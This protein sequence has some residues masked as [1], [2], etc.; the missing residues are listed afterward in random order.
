[1]NSWKLLTTAVAA[2][3]AAAPQQPQDTPIIRMNVELV[4]VDAVV[5]DGKGRH[6]SDLKPEDFEVRQDGKVVKITNFSYVKDTAPP[7]VPPARRV[8]GEVAAPP[9]KSDG[10]KPG[11]VRRTMA[12]VVDDLAL[13]FDGVSYVKDALL[14]FVD[15]QMEPG[16][17]VAVMRTSKGAGSLQ[18]F[19]SDKRLLRAAVEQVKF[20]FRNRV[21]QDSLPRIFDERTA[22]DAAQGG[23]TGNQGSTPVGGAQQ[24]LMQDLEK[25]QEARAKQQRE[26]FERDF[27]AVG[28]LGTLHYLMAGM[29]PLPGRKSVV[30]FSENLTVP[31]WDSTGIPIL[32]QLRRVTDEANRA[33]VVF[34]SVDPRG[35]PVLGF[36]AHDQVYDD[37]KNTSSDVL[38]QMRDNRRELYFNSRVG[39]GFLAEQT[40]GIYLGGVNDIPGLLGKAVADQSGYYLIGYRP[41]EG[42]FDDSGKKR[43]YHEIKV[44]VLPAGLH[45]RSRNGFYN[46]SESEAAAE[47][48]TPAQR[49]A[50]ALVSPFAAGEIGLQLTPVF[51]VDG[52]TGPTVL[53]MMH[54]DAKNLTFVDDGDGWRRAALNVLTTTFGEDG[55][56]ADSHQ[57][58]FKMRMNEARYRQIV[59]D[60]LIYTMTQ[61]VK[62]SGAFQ[63]RAVVGDINGS[64]LGS[65]SEFIEVPNLKK[66]KLALSG[67]LLMGAGGA[68]S[69]EEGVAAYTAG[70]PAIRHFRRGQKISYG[71]KVLNATVKGKDG[72][73]DV[74]TQVRLFRGDKE[75]FR[76]EPR[77]LQ[78][79]GVKEKSRLLVGG[80]LQLVPQFEPGDYALQLVVW[81]KL[82]KGGEAVAAQAIDFELD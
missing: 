38:L 19:T 16:D 60:G 34:Y 54:I 52:K 17:L 68:Q 81:D 59:K 4:Q 72:D 50:Q 53:T 58:L 45:S 48:M 70:H 28:T 69:D 5:T 12:L 49:L 74:W 64:K 73:P 2:L 78:V 6:V 43:K 82:A 9:A 42:T 13:S 33:G 3:M 36:Q 51:D 61:P 23:G 40:G 30:L 55:Q 32:D 56:M 39:L 80:A 21:G 71:Y 29:K 25:T 57:G 67:I 37:P 26:T 63:F 11:D 24:V 46:T 41:E 7:V 14:N 15:H 75:V 22:G 1:M 62:K 77:A 79:A 35:V 65:A 66:G 44:K 18:Q 76:S 47:A 27:F 31:Q 10:L 8:K 20:S